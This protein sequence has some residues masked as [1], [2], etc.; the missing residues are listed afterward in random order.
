VC[1]VTR[2][3]IS[4]RSSNTGCIYSILIVYDLIRFYLI[5]LSE[6]NVFRLRANK[7]LTICLGGG[8]V[9]AFSRI[10]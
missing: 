5:D 1:L 4:D 6:I 3:Q 8:G 7:M 2:T 10:E 9:L